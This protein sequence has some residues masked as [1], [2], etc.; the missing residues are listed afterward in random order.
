MK[1]VVLT[2]THEVQVR[3]LPCG[4]MVASTD[5]LMRVT[6][7]AIFVAIFGAGPVG[8]MSAYCSLLRGAAAV[9]VVDSISDRLKVAESLGAIPI[10]YR[11]EDP[12]TQIMDHRK[13]QHGDNAY[14]DEHVMDGVMCGI[15]AVGFQ[16]RARGD[17]ASEDPNWIIAALAQLVNPTGRIAIIGLF[18]AQDPGGVDP[19]EQTGRLTVPWATL[20]NKGIRVAFGRDQDKRYDSVLRNLIVEGRAKQSQIVSHRL[21]LAAAPDAYRHFNAREDDYVK[22]VLDPSLK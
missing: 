15:D 22:V 17:D 21:P 7:T 12:V 9:F 6:S 14:L 19:A 1:G 8:L 16:A 13:Q 10:D 20:F 4:E 5:V 3:E 11:I 18:Q 2:G